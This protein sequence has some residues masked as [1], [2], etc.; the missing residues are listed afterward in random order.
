[1]LKLHPVLAPVKVAVFP[2]VEADGLP[3]IALD[4]FNKLKFDFRTHYEDG[5]DSI[6]RRYRR[7]DALGTPYAITVDHDTKED[8]A[9]TIRERDS[10]AQERVKIEDIHGYVADRLS[11]RN[12]FEQL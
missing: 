4:I 3:E 1:M 9:V 12:V 5:R 11:I 10:M 8:G 2:L 7:M 6:G